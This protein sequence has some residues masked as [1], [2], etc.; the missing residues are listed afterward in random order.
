M[1][2]STMRALVRR[3]LKDEDPNHY[4]WSDDEIDRAIQRA[5]AELSRWVPREM[6]ADVQTTEGSYGLDISEISRRIRIEKVEFPIGET[7]PSFVRFST[8]NDTLT[9]LGAS[10][11][12]GGDARVY[13]TTVHTLDG[14]TSTVPAHLEHVVALGA[15]A[16]AVLAMA[17][18][19]T[20]TANI[21]GVE[22]DRDY[23][24]WG[25]GL[26]NEFRRALR[27]SSRDNKVRTSALYTEDT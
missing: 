27:A 22:A 21:G 8:F 13:Y 9:M 17:Q 26:L 4:R 19:V 6:T 11:G 20:E 7:P 5:V 1:D 14:S 23:R 3:D 2:L 25:L 24:Q 16:Y 12:D 18:Y 15:A 10:P